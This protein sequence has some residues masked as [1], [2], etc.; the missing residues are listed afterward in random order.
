MEPKA[1][2]LCTNKPHKILAIVTGTWWKQN[3]VAVVVH[4]SAFVPESFVFSTS[5]FLPRRG[6]LFKD[7]F[8]VHLFP[9]AFLLYP[10]GM[11]VPPCLKEDMQPTPHWNHD[12]YPL[13]LT[14]LSLGLWHGSGS[15]M[16]DQFP[17]YAWLQTSKA[18]SK[19]FVVR[20]KESVCSIIELDYSALA[21]PPKRNAVPLGPMGRMSAN[22]N[23]PVPWGE[24]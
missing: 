14:V 22:S 18:D 2:T 7:W 23:S 16:N 10:H 11:V 9:V 19:R 1:P 6:S 13:A 21:L 3:K 4:F 20:H 24:T 15:W 17:G 12:S 8:L 5:Y